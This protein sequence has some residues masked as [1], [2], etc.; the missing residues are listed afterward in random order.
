LDVSANSI[1]R[2]IKSHL[3]DYKNFSYEVITLPRDVKS[4]T[5][6]RLSVDDQREFRVKKGYAYVPV[7]VSTGNS[8]TKALVT[9]KVRLYTPVLIASR[10]IKKGEVLS[11]TDFIAEE[12][13]VTLLHKDP[14]KV[15][16]EFKDCR[17]NLNISAGDIIQVH[18]LE[19]TPII[20][21]GDIITAYSQF[22][23]VVVSFN[24]KAREEGFKGKKIKVL[25]DDK[26]IF[27]A[28]VI[29]SKS[30]IIRE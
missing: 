18:M 2:Y 21:R 13:E 5:D 16:E 15:D 30:V 7:I 29:D 3:D 26:R 23:T 6:P 25:R 9:L 17:A 4:I 20:L 11:V 19:Q 1:D 14:V 8:T 28:E 12:K 24:V 10:N 22:G 27:R